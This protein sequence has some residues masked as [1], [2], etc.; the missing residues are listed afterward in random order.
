MSVPHLTH[1]ARYEEKKKNQEKNNIDCGAPINQ[2]GEAGVS[3]T[4]L[5]PCPFQRLCW[6]GLFLKLKKSMNVL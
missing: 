1:H 5:A 2:L 6:V 4:A 3:Y